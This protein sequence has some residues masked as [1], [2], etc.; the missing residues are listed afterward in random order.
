MSQYKNSYAAGFSVC[1]KKIFYNV[2]KNYT[3]MMLLTNMGTAPALLFLGAILA[4]TTIFVNSVYAQESRNTTEPFVVVFAIQGVDSKTGYILTWAS[5]DNVTI[6]ALINASTVDLQDDAKD[7]IIEPSIVFPNSTV[8][9]GDN[10][11]ACAVVLKDEDL[12][13]DTGFNSPTGRAEFVS[14]RLSP[15]KNEQ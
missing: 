9:T 13:C 15:D 7:G 6:P 1:D 3:I 12:M 4:I 8:S 11:S 2:P 14:F 5:A 10:F